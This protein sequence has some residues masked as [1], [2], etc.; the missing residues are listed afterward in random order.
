MKERKQ[1]CLGVSGTVRSEGMIAGATVS[2]E[3]KAVVSHFKVR[4]KQTKQSLKAV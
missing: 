3:K 4:G 1:D 2:R